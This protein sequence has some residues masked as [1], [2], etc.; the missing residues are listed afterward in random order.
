MTDNR[1]RG[2]RIDRIADEFDAALQRGVTPVIEDY[3][4]DC[5]PVEQSKLLEELLRIELEVRREGDAEITVDDYIARFTD[6]TELVRRVIGGDQQSGEPSLEATAV[7]AAGDSTEPSIAES[8]VGG[9]LSALGEYEI[10]EEIARGGMGVVYKA[11]QTQ[12]NRIVALTLP[13]QDALL[14][15][16]A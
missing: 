11:R 1:S 15:T 9:A 10:I 3:L 2:A 13:R 8:S 14:M 4:R 6:E 5:P 12:L 16:V 7:P